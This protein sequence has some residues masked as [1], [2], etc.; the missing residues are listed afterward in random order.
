MG[1]FTGL[2]RWRHNP[3][4]RTTD[5]V[6]AW[7]ACAAVLLLVLG[8]PA[9]GL[10]AG[11]RADDALQQAARAQQAERRPALARVVREAEPPEPTPHQPDAAGETRVRTAVVARWSA[12]DG[13]PRSGTVHTTHRDPRPGDAFRIW[14][15]ADGRPV[16][17]PLRAGTARAHAVFAGLCAAGAV[18]VSTE[19]SR[20]AV[21]RGLIRRRYAALDRAWA[22]TGP[23]WGRTGTGS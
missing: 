10:W 13:L 7:I 19:A 3:L 16:T 12:P 15:D 14:T 20:R 4:R 23:D 8:A 2:W 21:V 22:R 17:A 6:E 5:L 9:T 18:A 1:T 11:L